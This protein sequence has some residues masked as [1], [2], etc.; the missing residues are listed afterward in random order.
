MVGKEE[1]ERLV[2][3]LKDQ[4][5]KLQLPTDINYSDLEFVEMVGSGGFGQV[6]KGKWKSNK[7]TVAIKK[8]P[9]LEKREVSWAI[10]YD[11]FDGVVNTLHF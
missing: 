4:T 5:E 10:L 2:E 9:A 8:T 6:W 1:L 11:W 7:R 3:R